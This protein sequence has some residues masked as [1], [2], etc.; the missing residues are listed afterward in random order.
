M[1]DRSMLPAY[2]SR[3]IWRFDECVRARRATRYCFK[4]KERRRWLRKISS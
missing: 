4:K 3:K 2:V 1:R